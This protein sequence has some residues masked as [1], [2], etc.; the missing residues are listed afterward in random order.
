LPAS[1][2]ANGHVG[3]RSRGYL[4]HA[5]APHLVQHVIIRLAD[6]LPADARKVL[7]TARP[8]DR[9]AIVDATLDQGHG[10]RDLADPIIAELVQNALLSFDGERYALL[11]WCVMP[12]HVHVL[13]EARSGYRLDRVVHS[14]KSY[15]GVAA[16]RA[17]GRARAFWGREYFDR[18]MRDDEHLVRTAAYIE[19]NAVKAGL[20]ANVSDWCFSSAWRGWGATAGLRPA[21]RQDA[22]APKA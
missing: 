6:S 14:W 16:N 9:V 13:V 8:V 19:G 21:C 22:G 7:D 4:P 12:N 1:T 20:C 5:D 17:L 2:S 3:W 10:R 11:A 18:F 15:T